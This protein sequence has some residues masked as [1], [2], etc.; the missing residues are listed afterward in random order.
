MFWVFYFGGMGVVL[1]PGRYRQLKYKIRIH[2]LGNFGVATTGSQNFGCQIE[3][4]N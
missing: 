4:T 2:K 1:E 3:S